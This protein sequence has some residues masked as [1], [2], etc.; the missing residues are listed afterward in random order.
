MLLI[1]NHFIL[2]SSNAVID[3]NESIFD[4]YRL[5]FIINDFNNIQY[6]IKNL[7]WVK[8]NY[9]VNDFKIFDLISKSEN[10]IYKGCPMGYLD[11]FPYKLDEDNNLYYIESIEIEFIVENVEINDFCDMKKDIINKDFIVIN[12]TNQI[13]TDTDYIIITSEIFADAAQ[14]LELIHSDLNIDI[15]FVD[16]IISLYQDLEIEYA[17]REYL[18]S[19]INSE[20]NLNYLLILG[21]ENII[22]PIYNGSTPSDD[23]YTSSGNLAANPQLSTGRIPINNSEDANNFVLKIKFYIE[24]L[25][26]PIDSDQSWRS[27]ITFVS[28]DEN[29]PNPNKYPELSH[30]ENS[31]LLYENMKHNLIVNTLYGIDYT[32]IQN[33]DGLLH[34]N[35]TAD[36]INHI[37]QGVSLIN[38]IGHGNYQ[39][40]ADE[41]ILDMDR[42]INLIGSGYYKLPIWIVGTCS[43]GEYDGKDS[44][45]EALLLKE[46]GAISVISTVRG[47]GETSNINYLTKFFNKI[48]EFLNDE[49]I[50]SYRL[51]DILRQSKNN[52][53]S[54]YLFH[55]FGDPAL[56]LP[57][58]KIENN[59]IDNIDELLIGEQTSIDLGV[60]NGH[61]NIF[62]AEQNIFRTYDTGDSIQY[63]IPGQSIYN[64]SFYN[65]ACFITSF[66]ASECSD[67]ASLHIYNTD[68]NIIQNIFEI[69]II[70]GNNNGIDIVGP[71]ISFF[72]DDDILLYSNDIAFLNNSIIVKAEDESG[73]NLMGGLGHDIRYWFNNEEDYNFIDS[74]LFNYTST[75]GEISSG[76][77]HIPLI[78][79]NLGQNTLYV[80]IWDNFNN[81]TVESIIFN[82]QND[83]F[84]AY[85]VYNFPNP[86]VDETY[87]TFRLS[88]APS[89]SN[90][91]IFDL[92][93][94]KIKTLQQE[95]NDLFCAIKWD[96]KNS[97]FKEVNNGT[98][99]Y[100]LKLNN[101]NNVFESIY[102]ITKLK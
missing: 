21:D 19:R 95:C 77:F 80:E 31:S 47:I 10:F 2:E 23:F 41:K 38:Y 48:N 28:D 54:E 36:L 8:S 78:D 43:F 6:K 27:N 93:G 30:T 65:Q 71:N 66:D 12:E 57:F 35:L 67:C 58:P 49:S 73:I 9:Q 29:N 97:D 96:G 52:S 56:P 5:E 33:S 89:I 82:I 16:D 88:S 90:I 25:E 39:T 32:P 98:Y 86:F 62:D 46:N 55:L 40:L 15:I 64:N 76:E 74:D 79:L 68:I 42:D 75:C 70:Q 3:S 14:N 100:H 60:Y 11:I 50:I 91:S 87:F 102:K 81:R 85:D 99:I 63:N 26:N 7:E 101:N 61:L 83:S 69:D 22:P 20:P 72:L 44:M 51:G 17:I 24:N 37:N 1:D 34:S 53:S 4:I 13:L 45:A 59:L 92:N 84:K 94:K 18:I